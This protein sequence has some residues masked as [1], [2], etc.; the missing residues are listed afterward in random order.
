MQAKKSLNPIPATMREKKRYI[1]FQIIGGADFDESDVLHAINDAVLSLFGSFGFA[2]ISPKLI[3]W[4]KGNATGILK[5]ERSSKDGAIAALQF[6]KNIK[7]KQ[8]LVNV[9]SVSGTLKTLR[10]KKPQASPSEN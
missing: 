1:L 7:G 6:I 9:I 10:E 4:H 5:C 2:R 8:A 3:E